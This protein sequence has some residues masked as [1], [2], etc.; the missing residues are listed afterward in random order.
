MLTRRPPSD[1]Q[2]T[3][4]DYLL[5]VATRIVATL[6]MAA[7]LGVEFSMLRGTANAEGVAPGRIKGL[8]VTTIVPAN[9]VVAESILRL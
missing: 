3:R 2:R 7:A 9:S 1:R 4:A 8:A 6:A 5:T